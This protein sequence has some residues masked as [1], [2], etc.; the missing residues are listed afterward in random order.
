M[1]GVK[2]RAFSSP[3]A[4]RAIPFTPEAI[5]LP[6][7][8]REQIDACR[9]EGASYEKQALDQ[10]LRLPYVDQVRGGSGGICF[11]SVSNESRI[12]RVCTE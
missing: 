12:L 4:S 8:T 6:I 9:T 5:R 2:I 7:A 11:P 1:T 10:V 3:L